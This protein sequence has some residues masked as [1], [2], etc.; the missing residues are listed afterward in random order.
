MTKFIMWKKSENYLTITSKPHA[1]P[2]IMKKTHAK[3][4]NNRKKLKEELRS[5]EVPTVYI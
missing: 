1:H 2:H 4:H 5:Q 3:F